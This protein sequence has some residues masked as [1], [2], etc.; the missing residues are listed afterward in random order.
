LKDHKF[1]R[2]IHVLTT[3]HALGAVACFTM[4]IGSALSDS[5]RESLMVSEGSRMVIQEDVSHLLLYN[6]KLL[7]ELSRCAWEAIRQYF[8]VCC[9]KEAL[10]AGILS[11]A[12]AGDFLDWN[13]HIHALIVNSL[14]DELFTRI[15]K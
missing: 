4:A 9:P 1:P 12:T 11:I 6:R 13:P 15:S 14:A 3:I 2:F 8:E 10:P 7:T 5:F